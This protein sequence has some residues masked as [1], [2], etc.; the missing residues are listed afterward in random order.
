M[1][2]LDCPPILPV[3]D[4]AIL[5]SKTDGTLIVYRVG[6]IARSALKRAKTLLENVRGRVLGV[7]LTG[8]KAETSPDYEE[9][10]YYRYAYGQE[11]GQGDRVQALPRKRS[12]LDK[13]KGPFS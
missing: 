11:P 1:V 4:A 9:L 7:V 12:F 5:A 6:K 13:I 8:L 2:I 10:Q 3:T